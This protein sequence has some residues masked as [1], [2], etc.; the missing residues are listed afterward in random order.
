M[1]GFKVVAK[2]EEI[3]CIGLSEVFQ[4]WMKLIAQG[5]KSGELKVITLT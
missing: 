1:Y 3:Y 2:T 4:A 5:F